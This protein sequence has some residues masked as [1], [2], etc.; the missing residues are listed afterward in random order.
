MD[1]SDRKLVVICDNDADHSFM[2][3]GELRN[4]NFE[5]VL[6]T[7]GTALLESVKSLRP[8][9]LLA[10]PDAPGFNE[11]DVCKQVMKEMN[12]PVLLLLN[13]RST[14]RATI[15]DCKADDVITKPVE[16]DSLA[17][18]LRTQMAWHQSNP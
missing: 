1:K 6:L 2:L 9:A 16:A 7:D 8:G 12:I 13:K 5:V 15:G 11:F 3:E 4:R 14:H 18:L 17:N 10:N